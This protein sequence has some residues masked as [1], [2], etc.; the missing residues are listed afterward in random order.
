MNAATRGNIDRYRRLFTIAVV[1]LA[2]SA[3]SLLL[4][5]IHVAASH[6]PLALRTF[7]S[8]KGRRTRTGC[9]RKCRRRG[10]WWRGS[11]TVQV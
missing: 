7:P 11:V 8:T 9:R 3:L 4:E 10:C 1:R 2:T 6:C 5:Y